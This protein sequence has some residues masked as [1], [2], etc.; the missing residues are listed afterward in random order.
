MSVLARQG[1]KYTIIGYAG[2]LLGALATYFLFPQNF[3]FYGE[4]NYILSSAEI[5]VPLVVFGV[6]YANVKYFSQTKREG[7]HQNIFLL[8]AGFILL[9]FLLFCL[10][11]F[12]YKFIFSDDSAAPWWRFRWYI[13]ALIL[14]LSLNHLANRY[15]SVFKRIAVPNIF[16]NLFPKIAN[17]LAFLLFLLGIGKIFSL[18]AFVLIIFISTIGYWFYLNRLEKIRFDFSLKYLREAKLT[19]PFFT[20]AFYGFLGNI[21]NFIAI[22]IDKLMIGNYISMQELGIYSTLLAMVSLISVPQLG[23]FSISAP[24]ISEYLENEDFEGLNK[25]HKNTSLKLFF[26]GSL[27][28]SALLAA[29][30]FLTFYIKN[31]VYLRESAPVCGF[32]ARP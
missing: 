31:G 29:F 23:L 22:K 4:L 27:L 32:W 21:G 18:L 7:K 11:F 10:L 24:A 28:F 5:F 30:P 14:L 20:Y 1:I 9:N 8:S 15:A 2:F 25:F 16:E 6:S 19:Q 12:S 13:L 26:L 3:A 17:I